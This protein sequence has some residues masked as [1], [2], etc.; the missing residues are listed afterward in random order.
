MLGLL[1]RIRELDIFVNQT[2]CDRLFRKFV[3]LANQTSASRIRWTYIKNENFKKVL[4]YLGF[5][6]LLLYLELLVDCRR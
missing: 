1:C 6:H 2:V 5:A 4:T 3:G